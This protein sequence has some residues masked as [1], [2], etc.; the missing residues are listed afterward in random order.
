MSPICIYLSNFNINYYFSDFELNTFVFGH[1][2]YG[3]STV[4]ALLQGGLALI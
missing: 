2:H 1:G 4:P 3:H